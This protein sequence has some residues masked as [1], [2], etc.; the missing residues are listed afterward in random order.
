[1]EVLQLL[2]ELNLVSSVDFSSAGKTKV[3]EEE[4]FMYK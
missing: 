3:R 2:I 4:L 1:M